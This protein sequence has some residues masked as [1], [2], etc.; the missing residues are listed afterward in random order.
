[1]KHMSLYVFIFAKMSKEIVIHQSL[2]YKKTPTQKKKNTSN[3][4]HI[5]SPPSGGLHTT[6][7]EPLLW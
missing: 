7:G 5:F 1:M 4:Q 2:L 6:L 3:R